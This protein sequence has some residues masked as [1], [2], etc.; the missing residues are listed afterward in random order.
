MWDL[1]VAHC[2]SGTLRG[3]LVLLV[4]LSESSL[5]KVIF[6]KMSYFKVYQTHYKQKVDIIFVISNR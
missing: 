4:C 1:I 5:S 3:L 6:V 2:L